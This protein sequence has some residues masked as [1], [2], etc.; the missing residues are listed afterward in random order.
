MITTKFVTKITNSIADVVNQNIEANSIIGQIGT[1][2][3]PNQC[4]KGYY[5]VSIF[6]STLTKPQNMQFRDYGISV[7]YYSCPLCCSI[8][9]AKML[10][11]NEYTIND[12]Y[13]KQC[14]TWYDNKYDKYGRHCGVTLANFPR[15]K[16]IG[17]DTTETKKTKY[18]DNRQY[19]WTKKASAYTGTN[20]AISQ[21]S[22]PSW[23]LAQWED[24]FYMPV[25]TDSGLYKSSYNQGGGA[26]VKGNLTASSQ[27]KFKAYQAMAVDRIKT[28]IANGKV[29]IIY[30]CSSVKKSG[31]YVLAIGF[32]N[33]T[34]TSHGNKYC[35]DEIIVHDPCPVSNAL[36]NNKTSYYGRQMTLL[37]S[38]RRL[39]ADISDGIRTIQTV[40][41]L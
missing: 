8:G 41:A 21:S 40:S 19:S 20:N 17:I 1:V 32:S 34:Y 37:D 25:S 22:H 29:D 7:W 2:Y 9:A 12:L 26:W 13:K 28:D 35:V 10:T 33:D 39:N 38:M 18:D 11:G 14:F 5:D 24:E 30:I 4:W 23:T 16:K 6:D 31:H 3:V 27:Q 15:M 36:Y